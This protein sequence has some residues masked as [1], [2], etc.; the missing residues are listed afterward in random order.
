V[1]EGLLA[2]TVTITGNGGDEIAAYLARPLGAGPFP[3]VL[4]IHHAPGWDEA[5]KEIVRKFAYHGYAAISPNL[6][7]RFGPDLAPD[8]AAAAARAGGWVSTE[9]FLGDAGAAVNYLRAM[10]VSNGKVGSIG[11]CSGGRQ[12]FLA[13]CELPIDAA[14]DCYGA[15]VI[16]KAPAEMP[17]P[18]EPVIDRAPKIACPILGLFGVEDKNPTPDEVGQI[19]AELTRLGKEHEFHMF[20]DTGHGFFSVDRPAY[21]V[22]SAVEGW[23]LVFEFYGRHLS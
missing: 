15:F 17:Y 23:R 22:A 9:Q 5:M 2:E 8:D 12:S 1:Y 6:Y 14:V 7:H 20:E 3:G 11:Y 4:V 16:A 18:M 10:P 13:A 19:D 21:R